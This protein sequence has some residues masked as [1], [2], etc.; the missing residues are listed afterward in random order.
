[1]KLLLAVDG[2]AHSLDAVKCVID[3][4]DWYRDKP[5]IELVTVHLPLPQLPGLGSTIGKAGIQ[6]YYQEEGERALA[7]AKQLLD[8]S[9]LHYE[10]RIL[11]GD[12]AET[13]VKHAKKAG[14]DIIAIGTPSRWIGSVANKVMNISDLPILLVK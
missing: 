8:R 12:P 7:E 3:H 14:C 5:G 6:R 9:G 11:V 10:A 2:S 4:A 13:M 1:M